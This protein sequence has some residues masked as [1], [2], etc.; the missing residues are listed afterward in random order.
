M[1]VTVRQRHHHCHALH[2]TIL[3]VLLLLP[4]GFALSDENDNYGFTF[5]D[6]R[7]IATHNSYHLD[8]TPEVLIDKY[9][10]WEIELDFGIPFDSKDFMVGHDGPQSKHGLV[11]L[12]DWVRNMLSA[13][14][15]NDHPLILKLEAK[16]DGP[17][18]PFRFPSFRCAS[19]W[20]DDWQHRLSDSL[21]LWIGEDNWMTTGQFKTML[22]SNWPEVSELAGKVIVTLQDSN[23]DQHIDT[24]SNYFF[25]RNIPGLTAAWPPI[26]TEVDFLSA[27]DSGINRFTMDDAYKKPWADLTLWKAHR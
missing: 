25:I 4:R 18:S 16:T 15:L 6:A 23:D 27:L 10:V 24:T 26:T 2:A 20:G 9:D 7:F 14:S 22:D 17:C 13:K 8:D 1:L 12:G 19:K 5:D 11:S 21:T 3:I